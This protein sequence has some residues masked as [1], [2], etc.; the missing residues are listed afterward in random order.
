MVQQLQSYKHSCL[1]LIELKS[2]SNGK[3]PSYVN[4]YLFRN[5]QL[6]P[7][8]IYHLQQSTVPQQICLEYHGHLFV[9]CVKEVC[10][11]LVNR[12]QSKFVFLPK[13]HELENIINTQLH[14]KIGVS[15]LLRSNRRYTYTNHSTLKVYMKRKL[16]LLYLKEVLKLQS[17]LFGR[18]LFLYFVFEIFQFV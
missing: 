2:I 8:I 13:E 1:L 15:R 5:E 17:N 14:N 12:L 16:S 7:F 3:Q 10:R 4:H 11:A 9:R 18:F 6:L